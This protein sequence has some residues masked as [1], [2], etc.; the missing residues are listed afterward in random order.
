MKSK[1]KM[2]DEKYKPQT[3]Q[4]YGITRRLKKALHNHGYSVLFLDAFDEH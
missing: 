4:L 3:L 2:S 1:K